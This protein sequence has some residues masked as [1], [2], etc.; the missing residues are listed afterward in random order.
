MNSGYLRKITSII[1]VCGIAIIV[2]MFA[3]AGFAQE[4]EEVSYM[5]SYTGAD[6]EMVGSTT[7]KACHRDQFPDGEEGTHLALFDANED[8]DCYEN[9][10]EACHGPGG[11]H[12][13]DAAGILNFLKMPIDAITDRCTICHDELGS[14]KLDDWNDGR[15]L[16]AGIACLGCHEGH[17]AND[18]FLADETVVGLC[19]A[20]H[21]DIGEAFANGEHGAPGTD[22]ICS[23]CHN[24]HD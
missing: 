24:P 2:L 5:D 19:S 15:H 18:Y 22:M 23:D 10:C 7:C 6:A 14:F 17:S 3:L 4:E 12:N 13:G 21:V 11:N 8:S 20:C 9:G 16:N 1:A